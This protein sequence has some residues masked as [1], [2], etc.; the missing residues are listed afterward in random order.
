MNPWSGPSRGFRRG[1]NSGSNR[2]TANARKGLSSKRRNESWP[3]KSVRRKEYRGVVGSKKTLICSMLNVDG[4]SEATFSDVR[5]TLTQRRP[6]LCII[7]ESKRRFEEQGMNI[8][9]EGYNV[10]EARRS[11]VSSD[12]GGG[13]IAVYTRISEGLI[14]RDYDPDIQNPD[15]QFARTERVWKTVE[16]PNGKTA[17]CGVYLG[18]QAS[19]DRNGIW[20]DRLLDL[21]RIEVSALRRQGFR[22]V[23]LGDFNAHLGN[24]DGIGVPGNHPGVNKNGLRFLKFLKETQSMHVNGNTD[25]TTGLWTR[26]RAGISTV[27]DYA[28]VPIDQVGS[29]KSLFVDDEG[30]L[31]GSSDHNWLELVLVDSF[32]RLK[33]IRNNSVKK[34]RWAITSVLDWT[35]F[36]AAVD[37]ALATLDT[38]VDVEVLAGSVCNILLEAGVKHVG[39]KTS[40][41]RSLKS[42]A[43]PKACVDALALKR[44]LGSN[45]KTLLSSLSKLSPV[46]KDEAAVAAVNIAEADFLDQSRLVDKLFMERRSHNKF[47]V[48][49][50]CK[51]FST[52]ALKC[53]WSYV[54]KSVKQS[55]DIDAVVTSEGVLKCNPHDIKDEVEKHLVKV[56]DGA[57]EPIVVVDET[58]TDHMYSH[59]VSSENIRSGDHGYTV[60]PSSGLPPS[61]GSGSLGTDPSGWINKEFVVSEVVLAVKRLKNSKAQGVDKLPNEFLKNAG[62]RFYDVLTILYNKV[63]KSGKFPAG[64]NRGRV[65]L[66]HKRSLR[67]ILGNY[68]PLTVI[69]ALSGLY[70]RLLNARLTEVVEDHHLLGEIQ[71]GFR[72][73]R[74]G[75]DNQFVLNS[76]MWKARSLNRKVHLGFVDISKARVL[77]LAN[78]VFCFKWFLF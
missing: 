39:L 29:V 37:T 28:V 27:I 69:N 54:N 12:K 13:G 67:E 55:C 63:K 40:R 78:F 65:V 66:V 46:L 3:H 10:S 44:Q 50:K 9:V 20:N 61:D 30:S 5:S 25:L 49:E 72:R 68:R 32:V 42:T 51:G 4:Y 15:H 17:I 21:L 18:F 14:F 34:E 43:L 56:F 11:D 1:R 16:T 74:M 22:T 58:A 57:T 71:N 8:E 35:A 45:W 75:S 70:S 41:G 53:F 19:D 64:W 48:L 60:P 38:T 76:I 52:D 7:I 62:K 2:R 73:G 24:I 36:T 23:L 47:K 31:G 77:S 6:D 33:R 59:P 26:H